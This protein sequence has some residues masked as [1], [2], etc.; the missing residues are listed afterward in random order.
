MKKGIVMALEDCV[1]RGICK[2][3]SS[4]KAKERAANVILEEI[5]ERT[6]T[7][8]GGRIPRN[9]F[10]SLH[11]SFLNLSTLILLQSGQ[12]PASNA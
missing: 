7:S 5:T 3:F 9:Q 10:E 1:A 11:A 6:I 8:I 12:Q 2:K 4:D